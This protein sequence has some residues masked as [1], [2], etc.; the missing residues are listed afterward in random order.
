MFYGTINSNGTVDTTK[1][2]SNN[3]TVSGSS[4]TYVVSFNEFLHYP[5]TVTA[6]AIGSNTS[7]N[8]YVG[9]QTTMTQTTVGQ[10]F[11]ATFW[12]WK[13]EQKNPTNHGFTFHARSGQ[14]L[15]FN[16]GV[17][18]TLSLNPSIQSF[19]YTDA[20]G[21]HRTNSVLVISTGINGLNSTTGQMTGGTGSYSATFDKGTVLLGIYQ[22]GG[23]MILEIPNTVRDNSGNTWNLT[24]WT[25]G[26][27]AGATGQQWAV[28]Q[29][30]STYPL[31]LASPGGGAPVPPMTT[32]ESFVIMATRGT[33]TL[34]TDPV[35]RLSNVPP[36]GISL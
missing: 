2:F 31:Q 35:I 27:G 32:P 9:V 33:Q 1:A 6:T 15:M 7:E 28:G 3:F 17:N 5:P 11:Q 8:N 22:G 18:T 23:T 36:A 30:S 34:T 12:V 24:G 26:A 29:S 14:S 20:N 25:Y 10:A 21:N 19:T 13:P 16:A 4:G